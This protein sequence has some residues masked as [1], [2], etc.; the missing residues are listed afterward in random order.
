[1]KLFIIA[2]TAAVVGTSA[3]ARNARVLEPEARPGQPTAG[4]TQTLDPRTTTTGQAPIAVPGAG[5]PYGAKGGA[6][7]NP[8]P[9]R[10][11]PGTPGG[12]SRP[13]GEGP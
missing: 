11:P 10:V 2:V 3:Y 5:P 4:P 8:N 9:D 1:M 12:A 7:G 13:P 6:T